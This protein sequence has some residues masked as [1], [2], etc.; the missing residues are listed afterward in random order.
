ME[1]KLISRAKQLLEL[2]HL[3]TRLVDLNPK[4]INVD[5]KMYASV[6]DIQ[7][8]LTDEEL[9]ISRET[10][11]MTG[12]ATEIAKSNI[13]RATGRNERIENP[14][15]KPEKVTKRSHTKKTDYKCSFNP[16][17][18][19]GHT[20]EEAQAIDAIGKLLGLK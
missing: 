11:A 16:D 1:N 7:A 3:L 9:K 8:F 17:C 15:V 18:D 10:N 5:G 4:T 6:D 14:K 2:S 19:G 13:L 12:V 20:K